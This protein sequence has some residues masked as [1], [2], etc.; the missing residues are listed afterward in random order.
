MIFLGLQAQDSNLT[1]SFSPKYQLQEIVDFRQIET[2]FLLRNLSSVEKTQ[3][4]GIA[5]SLSGLIVPEFNSQ[6]P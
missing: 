6:N 2:S 4:T 3:S 1:L 5:N